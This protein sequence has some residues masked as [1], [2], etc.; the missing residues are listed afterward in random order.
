MLPTFTSFGRSLYAQPTTCLVAGVDVVRGVERERL[1]V[2]EVDLLVGEA[3]DAD[4]RTA[5]VREDADVAARAPRGL[6]HQVDAT[7]V[8]FVLA[9]GEIDAR[10][11]EAGADH[12]GQHFDG[13]RG[14]A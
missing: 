5:E 4:L 13:V 9:V 14:R 6:V 11:V 7:T 12:F 2:L 8:L 10:D 1:A 3:L